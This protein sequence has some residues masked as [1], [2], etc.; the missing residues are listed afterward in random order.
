MRHFGF[1]V[2]FNFRPAIE[3][4]EKYFGSSVVIYKRIT[5]Q[6]ETILTLI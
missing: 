3:R 2:K 6:N 4:K 5:S 1:S